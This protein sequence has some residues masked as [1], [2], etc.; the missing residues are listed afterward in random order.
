MTD[1]SLALDLHSDQQF[2]HSS[3]S[4]IEFVGRRWVGVLLI[5]GQTG[6]RRFRDYRRLVPGISDRV[7]TQRLREL[8]RYG[9]L[10]RT[11]IPTAPVQ[12]LYA[13]TR[14]G[15]DLVQALQPLLAWGLQ[16]AE[17]VRLEARRAPAAG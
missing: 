7:L 9:L 8:E 10:E 16:E 2:C 15:A 14:R 4:V 5:A 11:V 13:P 1:L 17:L 6:A 12:I 3:R